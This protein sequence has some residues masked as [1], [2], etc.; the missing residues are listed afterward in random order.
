MN[1]ASSVNQNASH[2]DCITDLAITGVQDRMLISG[3]RDGI[4]KIWK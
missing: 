1:D 4:I 2:V 3:S